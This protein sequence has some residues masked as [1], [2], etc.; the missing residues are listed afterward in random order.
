[1]ASY[2][3]LLRALKTY[4]GE[5][6]A[7]RTKAEKSV[8][9]L[10]NQSEEVLAMRSRGL[11]QLIRLS[12]VVCGI[13]FC[14]AAETAFVTPILLKMG[15]PVTLMTTVWAISPFLGF[16][17][18]PL[19]GSL[20]D[21]CSLAYGRRRPFII[22]MSVGIFLGLLLVPNG[23]SLGILLGDTY[24][25][26]AVFNNSSGSRSNST[27]FNASEEVTPDS[28]QRDFH[29][30]WGLFFTIVGVVLLDLNCDGCQSP[31]RT[32]MLDVCVPEDQNQGLTVFT[33]LAGMGGSVGYVLGAIDWEK[34]HF[35]ERLGGHVRVVF[36]FV[37]IMYLICLMLTITAVKEVPLKELGVT[38]EK[39]QKTKCVKSG[40]KYTKFTSQDW[41]SDEDDLPYPRQVEYGTLEKD[42]G[43]DTKGGQ[44]G[45]PRTPDMKQ[46]EIAEV[47]GPADVTLKTYLLSIVHMPASLRILC[48]TNLF[49]WSSLVCYSLNFTDFVGQAVYGGDPKAKGRCSSKFCHLFNHISTLYR[50][51]HE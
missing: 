43:Q 23:K 29:N 22:A 19:V 40:K 2:P 8:A 9:E 50:L 24:T 38:I 35:G 25:Y 27:M 49:C 5:V 10:F 37:V 48:L 17:L 36:I 26:T 7:M 13:E 4:R 12:C 11:G 30:P 20:S 33:I 42:T 47:S 39:L 34:T 28:S 6:L 21:R 44:E 41:L 1:M 46:L 18:I 16:F 3:T 15:V 31:S 32:Y 14:Y 51:Y 45:R